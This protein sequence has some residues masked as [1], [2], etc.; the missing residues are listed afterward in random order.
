MNKTT[1]KPVICS[2]YSPWELLHPPFSL[3]EN[4]MPQRCV[5]LLIRSA[6]NRQTR[7]KRYKTKM[8]HITLRTHSNTYSSD[9]D[10]FR[11]TDAWRLYRVTSNGGSL[12]YNWLL[13]QRRFPSTFR[14]FQYISICAIFG[15]SAWADLIVGCLDIPINTSTI[16][17]WEVARILQSHW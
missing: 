7:Q 15:I 9:D 12:N 6:Q 8:D 11:L 3:A 14:H 17:F 13:P 1:R 16:N 2:W 5:V 10:V 4:R